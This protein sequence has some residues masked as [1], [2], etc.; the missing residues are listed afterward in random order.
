MASVEQESAVC[1]ICFVDISLL[2]YF[3]TLKL[4][5]VIEWFENPQSPFAHHYFIT[6]EKK[7]IMEELDSGHVVVP[8]DKNEA[9]RQRQLMPG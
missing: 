2:Y 4:L 6:Y 3:H 9:E 8:S 7:K 5:I 1:A